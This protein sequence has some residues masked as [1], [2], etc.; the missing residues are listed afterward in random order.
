[1]GEQKDL[2]TPIRRKSHGRKEKSLFRYGFDEL[3]GIFLNYE[4]KI[5]QLRKWMILLIINKLE[6]G[7]EEVSKNVLY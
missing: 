3:R 5:E 6:N 2:E 7:F 4:N 1:M